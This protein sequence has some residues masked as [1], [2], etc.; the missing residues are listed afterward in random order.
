MTPGP[1]GDRHR[2]NIMNVITALRRLLDS[3]ISEAATDAEAPVDQPV[4]TEKPRRD[5][6]TDDMVGGFHGDW[7]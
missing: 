5:W 3:P 6:H 4:K 7:S 2:G 1:E